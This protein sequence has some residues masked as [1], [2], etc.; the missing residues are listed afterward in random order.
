VRNR[1]FPSRGQ[2]FTTTT[3]TTTT[4]IDFI[5]IFIIISTNVWKGND[6]AVY[7]PPK[8]IFIEEGRR[9]IWPHEVLA[10]RYGLLVYQ[11]Q[12][13]TVS[14]PHVDA[15]V[16]ATFALELAVQ[17]EY[18]LEPWANASSSVS[19]HDEVFMDSYNTTDLLMNGIAS[20]LLGK[21][22]QQQQQQMSD[23]QCHSHVPPS[24]PSLS[25]KPNQ[26]CDETDPK[27]DK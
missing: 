27:S 25:L 24:S 17:W 5:I 20:T 26:W 19:H 12:S 4:T 14:N 22:Q 6:D 9:H 16:H 1:G 21:L 15:N 3:T 2:M 8:I 10:Q 11:S 7:T 13:L 23:N 18:L